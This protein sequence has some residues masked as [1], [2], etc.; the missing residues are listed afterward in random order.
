MDQLPFPWG[1]VRYISLHRSD[2]L[3]I[4][5][6]MD[7]FP[8]QRG[9]VRYIFL[10]TSD[11]SARFFCLT[12]LAPCTE[13]IWFEDADKMVTSITQPLNFPKISQY[14]HPP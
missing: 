6:S 4:D 7:Q 12:V 2:I 11:I 1:K 9:K 13:E 14:A 3:A 10:H 8:L 5:I